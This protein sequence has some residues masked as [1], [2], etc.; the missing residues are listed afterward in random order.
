[1]TPMS[2][3]DAT[4]A[5]LREERAVA[6]TAAVREHT[7]A[8][9]ALTDARLAEQAARGRKERAYQKLKQVMQGDTPKVIGNTLVKINANGGLEI[10]A[11]DVLT[12]SGTQA[13]L[14]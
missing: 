4:A 11:V 13:A 3:V 7:A 1:M 8:E 5:R 2:H 10:E 6:I 9:A 14:L 12:L